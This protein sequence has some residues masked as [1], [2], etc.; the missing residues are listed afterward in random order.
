MVFV[1]VLLISEFFASHILHHDK[2]VCLYRSVGS[3]D[4]RNHAVLGAFIESNSKPRLMMP[5]DEGQIVIHASDEN[6][7]EEI[8]LFGNFIKSFPANSIRVLLYD[9]PGREY[10]VFE[11]CV[12]LRSSSIGY[13][14]L[15]GT[16]VNGLFDG[17][18][19]PRLGEWLRG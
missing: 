9:P 15:L 14:D 10:N 19:S 7:I 18:C 3:I 17:N 12:R 4:T 2:I 13:F 5:G 11:Y 8:R 1:V 16:D 6:N